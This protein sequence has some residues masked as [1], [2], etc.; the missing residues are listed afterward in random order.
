MSLGI[1]HGG[2]QILGS[3]SRGLSDPKHWGKVRRY[4]CVYG[5]TMDAKVMRAWQMG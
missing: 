5:R 3:H 2:R 4:E 1:T